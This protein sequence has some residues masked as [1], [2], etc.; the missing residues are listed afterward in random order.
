MNKQEKEEIKEVIVEPMGDDDIRYYFPDSTIIKYSELAEI[1]DIE[2]LLRDDK[3]FF[4]LLYQDQPNSGHWVCLSRSGDTIEYFDSYGGKVDEP[5]KWVPVYVSQNLGIQ[6]PYLSRLLNKTRL[7]VVYNPVEY[8]L[9]K[10]NI[11]TC[12]RHCCFRL[13]NMLKGVDLAD[14]YKMIKE[15]KKK[16]KVSYDVI[17]SEFIKK[18]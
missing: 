17:V 1:D 3:S 7:N 16:Y 13:K 5:L 6:L 11:N 10:T 8:Q 2:T 15:L 18:I 4:F 14:Y 9:D 12:G